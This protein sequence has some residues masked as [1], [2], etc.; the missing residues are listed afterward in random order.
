[1]LKL[2]L[3][4]GMRRGEI[5]KLHSEDLDFYHHIIHLRNPK[6]GRDVSIPMSVIAEGI[7]KE[8]IEYRSR[9]YPGSIYVFPGRGG[10]TD[11]LQCCEKD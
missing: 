9:V 2:A 11:R 6:G 3:F 4:T 7:L 8:Q 5:F 10:I 1:M